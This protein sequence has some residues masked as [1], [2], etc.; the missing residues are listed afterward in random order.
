MLDKIHQK[1]FPGHPKYKEK[2]DDGKRKLARAIVIKKIYDLNIGD[3]IYIDRN[4]WLTN[5]YR[6]CAY[7][8]FSDIANR[9]F[10]LIDREF[11][12]Y[13]SKSE[14]SYSIVI[15]KHKK[16]IDGF[17]PD[18]DCPED[19]VAQVKYSTV[20]T[21]VIESYLSAGEALKRATAMAEAL[22]IP[23]EATP[24]HIDVHVWDTLDD[25]GTGIRISIRP[26]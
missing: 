15:E 13:D 20:A 26:D 25:F 8:K 16:E 21:I 19:N 2:P 24:S 4:D 7:S 1:L 6:V 14:P 12:R 18:E 23:K 5:Q 9:D 22:H 11:I 10:F 3:S 17:L